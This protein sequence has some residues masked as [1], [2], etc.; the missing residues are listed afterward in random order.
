MDS[1][2]VWHWLV[3]LLVVGLAGWLV[4]LAVRDKRK[5]GAP[6]PV[7]IGGWLALLAFGLCAGLIKNLVEVAEGIPDLLRGWEANPAARVPLAFIFAVAVAFIAANI[8]AIV[9]LFRKK[10]I[11]RKA[12]LALWVMAAVTPLSVLVMLTVP[13]VTPQMLMPAAELAKSIAGVCTMG[14]WYWYISVSE[15]VRNTMVH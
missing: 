15:R 11:F 5:A 12:Y 9:S 14:L 13:G 4:A 8:W 7:G 10:A 1:F 3:V 6:S 2:S